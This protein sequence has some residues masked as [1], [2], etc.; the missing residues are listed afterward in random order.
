MGWLGKRPFDTEIGPETHDDQPGPLL[1]H[2]KIGGVENAHRY[3]VRQFRRPALQCPMLPQ[4]ICMID[5]ALILPSGQLGESQMS[6]YV[7]QVS[8]EGGALEASHVFEYKR[9]WS[10]LAHSAN[11]LREHVAPVEG[12]MVLSAEGKWLAWRPARY[13]INFGCKR[14]V[15]QIANI[16]FAQSP[17]L[18]CGMIRLLVGAYRRAGMP[19]PVNHQ[20]MAESGP[21]QSHAETAS[22]HE[23]FDRPQSP[24]SLKNAPMR[25]LDRRSRLIPP[26]RN[27]ATA[28]P[29]GK[30]GMASTK[31]YTIP[32]PPSKS[33]F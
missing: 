8:G 25:R 11:R 21:A 13:E 27:S 31:Q 23:Q 1:R 30:F 6:E 32:K 3:P 26:S 10:Q 24:S 9:S 22:A 18:H 33:H 7:F 17:A 2:A 29:T 19:V 14:L 16:A 4:P 15:T 12:A 5:P 20:F 28:R